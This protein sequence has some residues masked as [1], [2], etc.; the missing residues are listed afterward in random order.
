[1]SLFYINTA[2]KKQG[3]LRREEQNMN[4]WDKMD[5]ASIEDDIYNEILSAYESNKKIDKEA[6]DLLIQLMQ[7]ISSLFNIDPDSKKVLRN[8][9]VLIV[10][11][12]FESNME[13]SILNRRDANGEDLQS[14]KEILSQIINAPN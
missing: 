9:I 14:I 6:Y 7:R 3:I 4:E 1:M 2:I 10:N 13:L 12:F 8:A 5:L 11:L